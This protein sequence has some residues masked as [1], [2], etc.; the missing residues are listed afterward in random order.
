M[1]L[2]DADDKPA[3]HESVFLAQ[4]STT[5]AP[6]VPAETDARG[7]AALSAPAWVGGSARVVTGK[8]SGVFFTEPFQL[9]S[10]GGVHVVLHTY[11]CS[12]QLE[13]TLTAF[14]SIVF[15]EAHGGGLKVTQALRSYN[16]ARV[17]WLP[18]LQLDLPGDASEF[19]SAI[20]TNSSL[21]VQREGDRAVIL[22]TMAPGKHELQLSFLL[23]LHGDGARFRIAMPP[24]VAQA[25]V[26][27]QSSGKTRLVVKGFPEATP[28]ETGMLGTEFRVQR[29]GTPLTEVDVEVH[30]VASTSPSQDR[31]GKK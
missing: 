12:K 24:H 31:A 4:I 11:A 5:P 13:D 8:G 28:M 23:P 15:V 1:E 29:Q 19:D 21:A 22:G 9:P 14:Q 25:R 3:P 7:R 17:A 6:D 27:A 26:L 16:F 10:R 18:R 2:R 30:A 20:E